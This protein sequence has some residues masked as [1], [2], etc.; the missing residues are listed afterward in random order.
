MQPAFKGRIDKIKVLKKRLRLSSEGL[1]ALINPPMDPR[2]LDLILS[3]EDTIYR[4]E[5][6]VKAIEKA[7]QKAAENSRTDIE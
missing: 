4:D 5:E 1:A 3:R 6:T 2:E 7:L